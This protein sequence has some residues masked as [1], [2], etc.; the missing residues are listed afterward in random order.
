MQAGARLGWLSPRPRSSIS[1]PTLDPERPSG[2]SDRTG[3]S[4]RRASL[5]STPR[6]ANGQYL[7][8]SRPV[9]I[10]P[11]VSFYAGSRRRPPSSSQVE[12]AFLVGEPT[13]D[14]GLF[15]AL[16]RLAEA[17]A[18]IP[19]SKR[20]IRRPRCPG[21]GC[22]PRV[23]RVSIAIASYTSRDNLC[24]TP[25]GLRTLPAPRTGARGARQRSS[26]ENSKACA[27]TASSSRP[28][29]VRLRPSRFARR[30]STGLVRPFLSARVA[31]V[32]GSLWKVEVAGR[33]AGD[34]LRR[35]RR[36]AKNTAGALRM[37]RLECLADP[38]P[39]CAPPPVRPPS[40]RGAAY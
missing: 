38:I 40:S 17:P 30:E 34:G 4:S 22:D 39:R 12:S 13:F 31:A 15:P 7:I 28:L 37:A 29:G 23:P 3:Q 18:E 27:S 14:R 21:T 16:P 5:R 10:V 8:E 9:A 26:P 33:C 11:S 6:F 1:D 2:A 19:L 35:R 20:S 25:V 24:M 32:L 36:D